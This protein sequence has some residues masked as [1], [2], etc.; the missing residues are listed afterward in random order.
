[1]AS[2]Q[3]FIWR[4]EGIVLTQNGEAMSARDILGVEKAWT[5]LLW[6]NPKVINRPKTGKAFIRGLT[7]EAQGI[8]IPLMKVNPVGKNLS[9]VELAY[10]AGLIDGDGA[11][12]A[13]IERHPEKK[14]KFRVRLALKVTLNQKQILEWIKKKVKF[15]YLKKNRNQHEW[16]TQDQE[17]IENFLSEILF[18]LKVKRKQ[19][20][21][22]LK[23]AKIKVKSFE[24]LVKKAKLADS[25]AKL[26]ARSKSIRKN[27]SSALFRQVLP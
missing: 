18:F 19:A 10:L 1:V 27:F 17:K 14:F 16:C 6:G 22:A 15:G 12:M 21:I 5:S 23:I 7:L 8:K 11:I 2:P 9:K 25:L 4:D 24:D 20:E 13:W 26:N 3:I